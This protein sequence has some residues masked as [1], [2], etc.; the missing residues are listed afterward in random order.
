MDSGDA[1]AEPGLDSRERCSGIG[2]TQDFSKDEDKSSGLT[3]H[4]DELPA[5]LKSQAS[6]SD[7]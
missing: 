3:S 6:D 1:A 4:L 5:A 7:L 2:L